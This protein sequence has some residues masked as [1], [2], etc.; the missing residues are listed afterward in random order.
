[1]TTDEHESRRQESK[2]A[3]VVEGVRFKVSFLDKWR[4]FMIAF[5]SAGLIGIA[6]FVLFAYERV[7]RDG[8]A[9]IQQYSSGLL[10][11]II[12]G[13]LFGL[14]LSAIVTQLVHA[15]IGIQR[16]ERLLLRYHE[17]LHRPRDEKQDA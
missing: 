13:L 7:R 11:G 12:T 8:W 10:L 6:G 3:E 16:N 1:M 15:I 14:V 4:P 9:N 17:R 2:D 5:W